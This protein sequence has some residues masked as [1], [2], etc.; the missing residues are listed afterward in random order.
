MVSMARNYTISA[1]KDP[2]CATT[3]FGFNGSYSPWYNRL[4]NSGSVQPY[5]SVYGY[6]NPLPYALG[7]GIF[8]T[9]KPLF[10]G[11]FFNGISFNYGNNCNN[12]NYVHFMSNSTNNCGCQS[13]RPVPVVHMPVRTNLQIGNN[14]LFKIVWD[15]KDECNCDNNTKTTTNTKSS[16]KSTKTSG[17][18]TNKNSSKDVFKVTWENGSC[19]CNGDYASVLDMIS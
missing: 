18:T 2:I 17:T 6:I 10:G 1:G 3:R 13:Q 5:Q 15:Q 11:G 4:A 9:R 8:N 7:G 19:T 16:Q 14:E 12:N